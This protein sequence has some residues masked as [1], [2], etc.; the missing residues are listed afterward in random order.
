MSEAT[1]SNFLMNAWYVCATSE[2]LGYGKTLGRYICNEPVVIYRKANGEAAALEDRCCH[3]R[4]PLS[5]GL[6]EGDNIR[7][8]YHGFVFNDAGTCVEIPGQDSIPQKARVQSYP[9][10]ERNTWVWIWMGDPEL[11][12]P[13][14][15]PDYHWFSNPEWRGKSVRLSVKANYKLIIQNLLDLS[16]LAFVHGT[17]I[18][19]R[20][21]VDGASVFFDRGD[22]EVRV[23]RWMPNVPPPPTLKKLANFAGHVDRWHVIHY[24]PPS[25]VRLYTGAKDAGTGATEGHRE[26]GLELANLNFITPE[27]DKTSHYFW[28]QCHKG[29]L[30]RPDITNSLFDDVMVAFRQDQAVFE[31]QQVLIDHDPSKP[32]IYV[33]ADA[34]A[35]HAMRILDRLLEE[36]QQGKRAMVARP[37]LKLGP[38]PREMNATETEAS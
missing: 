22:N 7:C 24:T 30:D 26:G 6:I 10:V 11:A 17:T 4:Y 32:E 2:E 37:D 16:H 27:T 23:T 1:S 20:A 9:V 3:R 21:T 34:G 31:D 15:I 14:N 19:N 38:W 5:K 18:G 29:L 12:N 33:Q 36:Q 25:S 28:G 35:V 8:S 13:D